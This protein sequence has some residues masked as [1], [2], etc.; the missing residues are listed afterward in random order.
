MLSTLNIECATCKSTYT[1]SIK[2]LNIILLFKCSQCDQYN[3][4]VAGQVL[5]LDHEIMQG[6]TQQ[7]RHQHIVEVLQ[8]W[9]C[10]FAGNV[11]R[12]VNR[13]VDVNLELDLPGPETMDSVQPIKE[14]PGDSFSETAMLPSAQLPDAPQI[15]DEEISDFRNIDLNLIDRKWYF[16]KIFGNN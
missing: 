6:A 15:S 10:E 2:E 9:A 14:E 11:L 3:V 16:D 5:T 4:Y 7:Q 1:L 13:V 12:N 8:T